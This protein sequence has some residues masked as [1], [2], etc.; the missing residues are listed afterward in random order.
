M[1]PARLSLV[2][3]DLGLWSDIACVREHPASRS[4]SMSRLTNTRTNASGATCFLPEFRF[5]IGSFTLFV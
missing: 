2:K 4:A 5:P 3:N 1:N